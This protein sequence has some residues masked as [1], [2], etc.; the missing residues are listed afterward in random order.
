VLR[1]VLVLPAIFLRN[2]SH[3]PRTCSDRNSAGDC[4]AICK[5][6]NAPGVAT[7]WPRGNSGRRSIAY[8]IAVPFEGL[9]FFA[10]PAPR[11]A[12]QKKQ[13]PFLAVAPQLAVR[14]V[15]GAPFAFTGAK[16]KPL[17]EEARPRRR[18]LPGREDREANDDG[19]NNRK[20]PGSAPGPNPVFSQNGASSDSAVGSRG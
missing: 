15:K 7:S 5:A 3:C 19:A 12:V 18:L 16:R 8:F 14:A 11:R 9:C 4:P 6:A 10:S 17:T 1:T 20:G 2:V 13:M